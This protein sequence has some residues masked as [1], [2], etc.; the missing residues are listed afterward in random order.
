MAYGHSI[1]MSAENAAVQRALTRASGTWGG[2]QAWKELD[3]DSR[4]ALIDRV[5]RA[6]NDFID[7]LPVAL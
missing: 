4:L 1:R 2:Y 7:D 5:M 6:D 3:A